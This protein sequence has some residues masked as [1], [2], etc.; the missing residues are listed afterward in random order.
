ML[1]KARSLFRCISRINSGFLHTVTSI[2]KPWFQNCRLWAYISLRYLIICM[3]CLKKFGSL[4]T[5]PI[6]GFCSIIARI[7]G[8]LII[9]DRIIS[10]K[11]KNVTVRRCPQQYNEE[12]HPPVPGLF[13]MLC[14]MGDSIMPRMTSGSGILPPSPPKPPRPPAANGFGGGD[15]LCCV[16][17]GEVGVCAVEEG[18]VGFCAWLLPLLTTWI[19]CPSRMSRVQG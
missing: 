16:L 17:D 13:M 2:K 9:I 15:L 19:T 7:C 12:I 10:G 5:W 4:M 11:N 18:L 3:D 14:I 6:S 1:D 8:L